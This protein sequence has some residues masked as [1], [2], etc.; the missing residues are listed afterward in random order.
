MGGLE[1]TAAIRERERERGGHIRIVAMTAHAMKGDRD[2]CLAAGMD[3]YL[4][5]PID[6]LTL[7]AMLEEGAVAEKPKALPA[8]ASPGEAPID[9]AR[10]MER[11]GGDPQLFAV[12]CR[13]FLDDCPVRLAA[14]KVAVDER[15]AEGIRV[16]AHALKGAAGNLAATGLS[17]A[18]RHLELIGAQVRMDAAGEGWQRLSAEAARVMEAL[19]EYEKVAS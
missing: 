11:V 2:R 15:D 4:S 9:R 13:V 10:L 12:I 16:S 5:K 6:A 18:A 7:Y 1:A 14:I 8:Q 3:A 17:E 19:Q